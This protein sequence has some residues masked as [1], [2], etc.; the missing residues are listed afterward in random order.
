M[1]CGSSSDAVNATSAGDED[2]RMCYNKKT[3]QYEPKNMDGARPEDD[4]FE[5]EEAGEGEQFMA[6][7]PWRGQIA[8]PANHNP[9]NKD[10]PACTY[11]IG[12]AYG[13]RGFDA[14]NN[15]YHNAN[16]CL[17][18]TTAA[19]GVIYDPKSHS[20]MYFG[21]GEVEDKAK[22]VSNDTHCHTDDIM[23]LAVCPEGKVAL[24]GQNGSAPVAFLWDACTG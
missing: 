10:A 20:Q 21:G 16:D 3:G 2:V 22:N 8:E 11:K 15:L 24:S 19:L 6:V 13:Y 23:C 17:V 18:Y 9:V 1:G 12:W 14:R 7:K 4:F 5:V